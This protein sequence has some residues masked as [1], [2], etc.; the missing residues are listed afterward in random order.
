[1]PS[2]AKACLALVLSSL[3]LGAPVRA[4]AG[5]RYWDVA[6]TSKAPQ[7]LSATGLYTSIAGKRKTLLPNAWHFEV[8]S[9]LWSDDAK[10]SRWVLL[11]PGA[12]IGFRELDDY[13]DY[14]D[15][16]VFIKQFA[17]DTVP[18]DTATRVLWET[19]LLISAREVLDSAAG[20]TTDH[21]YGFSYKW[22]ADQKDA[23]LVHTDYNGKPDSI[24]IWPQGRTR[25][26]R[27]KK[28]IF[29][30][31]E[32]CDRCHR[33]ESNGSMHARSVLGF[34]TAQLNRP[35]PDSA[36]VNQLEYFFAK[37][38]L[39]GPRPAA[40]TA[41]PRW[42]ALDDRA[43]SLDVRARSYIASNCSGCHGNRGNLV[44]AAE[45]CNLDYDYLSM[46]PRMEFRHHYTR[47]F[48][49]DDTSI[50]PYFYPATDRGNNPA[51]LDSLPIEPALVVPGYPQ[52]SVILFRQLARNTEPGNY[53]PAGNMM[54]PLASFEV[55]VAATDSIAKWIREMPAIP[56]PDPIRAARRGNLLP[57]ATLRGR[58]LLL[59]P[60][61]VRSRAPV[62]MAS[63][64]GR[65]VP[66]RR[67][68]EDVYA[69]PE[70]VPKGLYLI[71]VGARSLLRYLL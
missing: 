38:V 69:V 61:T 3:S 6:D 67:L 51:G 32:Q 53:D 46:T 12:S 9:A 66:L 59:A 16:T 10:K 50:T 28:W 8:N 41:S 70:G 27:M 30:S 13:W 22:N 42:R 1:M 71:R 65:Q 37:Q 25:P 44:G 4:A 17:I 49:L 20:T 19:R 57:G 18:G 54:P 48:G 45:M 63:M 52:K 2:C 56:A 14:P 55:N 68:A 35:H 58:R 34:F 39:K 7:L 26:A 36:G 43:A 40:W 33:S 62:S 24:R 64:D 5:F 11:K 21:W 47:S 29:P 60:E 31:R 15:S 23:R